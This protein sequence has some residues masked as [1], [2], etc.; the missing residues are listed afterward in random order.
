MLEKKREGPEKKKL[1]LNIACI[2]KETDTICRSVKH[3]QLN[4]WKNVGSGSKTPAYAI[5]VSALTTSQAGVTP[6]Y[7]ALS[8]ETSVI[9]P[10]CIRRSSHPL[11]G[12]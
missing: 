11:N 2:T 8:V 6:Q 12:E 5:A 1:R 3:S 10:Y 4:P 9:V 7:S